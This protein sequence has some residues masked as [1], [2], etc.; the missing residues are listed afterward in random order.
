MLTTFHG[1]LASL[2]IHQKKFGDCSSF[3]KTR[4]AIS[5]A[6]EIK[7]LEDDAQAWV[8]EENSR[9]EAER[10]EE[11]HKQALK[12]EMRRLL[13]AFD[14]REQLSGPPASADSN[15][16]IVTA[17]VG[18]RVEIQGWRNNVRDVLECFK[19]QK[20]EDH[21]AMRR[22]E[23]GD[24]KGA[25]NKH[26]KLDVEDDRDDREEVEDQENEEVEEIEKGGEGEEND[27][28]YA[29]KVAQGPTMI[30]S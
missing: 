20:A 7:P 25:E 24:A 14:K 2:Q 3:L 21:E 27:A 1:R 6:T 18:I 26:H 23:S 15:G 4:T 16:T 29:G 8:A 22:C 11:R 13:E 12:D 10:E 17:L 28:E 5:F 19:K 30:A 9:V